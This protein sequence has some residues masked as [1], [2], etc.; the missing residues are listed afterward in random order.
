MQTLW[1]T[2]AAGAWLFFSGAVLFAGL[3]KQWWADNFGELTRDPKSL[4]IWAVVLEKLAQGLG[5]ALLVY[6]TTGT[7]A[8]IVAI[9]LLLVSTTYLLSTYANYRVRG[10]PVV[11]I[12]ALDAVRMIVATV[13]VALVFGRPLV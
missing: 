3:L 1:A 12:A 4:P 10:G 11:V 6:W 7:A 8:Q 5:L 2:L 9:P 13:I